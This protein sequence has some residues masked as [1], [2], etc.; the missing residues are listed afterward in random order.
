MWLFFPHVLWDFN[1]FDSNT[2]APIA[3]IHRL[4][5]ASAVMITANVPGRVRRVVKVPGRVVKIS[6]VFY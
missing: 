5:L 3:F 1:W 4:L 2:P 6:E